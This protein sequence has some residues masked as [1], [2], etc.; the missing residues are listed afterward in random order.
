MKEQTIDG[1]T[2]VLV[3]KDDWEKIWA[4]LDRISELGD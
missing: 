2:H 3:P 4:V 1:I